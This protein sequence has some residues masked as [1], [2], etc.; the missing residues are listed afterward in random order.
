M[1]TDPLTRVP[2]VVGMGGGVVD[3]GGE[4]ILVLP[5]CATR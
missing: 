3:E 2:G 1:G 4:K 5:G